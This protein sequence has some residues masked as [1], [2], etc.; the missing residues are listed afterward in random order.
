MAITI[1][2]NSDISVYSPVCSL[3]KHWQSEKGEYGRTC[4]AFPEED[5][6]PLT[7]WRGENKHT[8]PVAGDHGIRFERV[9]SDSDS[10][11][12]AA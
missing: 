2:A 10:S 6:I 7:I 5:S 11:R 8:T 9:A 3:C 4:A 1:D 12:A